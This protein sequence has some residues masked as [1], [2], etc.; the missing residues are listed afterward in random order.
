[1]NID[2]FYKVEC[3]IVK[4]EILYVLVILGIIVL[5]IIN[6]CEFI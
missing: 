5:I 6:Y 2:I 1:M 4:I 3:N